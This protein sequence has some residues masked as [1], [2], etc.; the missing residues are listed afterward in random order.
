MI[1]SLRNKPTGIF[2]HLQGRHDWI[3]AFNDDGPYGYM[4]INMDGQG[5]AAF[6]V[7]MLR[8]GAMVFKEL[9]KDWPLV[10]RFCRANECYQLVASNLNISDERWP[11][12]IKY[13]GFPEPQLIWMSVQRV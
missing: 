10:K 1:Y 9:K 3:M 7:H 6:H 8:W 13:F 12:F 2:E 5:S 11:K 4:A